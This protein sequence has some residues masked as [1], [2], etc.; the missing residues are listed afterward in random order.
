MSTTQRE[1]TKAVSLGTVDAFPPGSRR[2]VKVGRQTIAVFNIDG[3][4]HAIYGLCPH[5]FAPLS[6]GKLQGTLI[7]GEDTDWEKEWAYDG[8]VVVCPGHAMEFHVKTG[9]AFG[10]DFS[11]RTYDVVIDDGEILLLL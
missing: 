5:Q 8:E 9:K 11:L 3:E 7:C 1:R 6:R 10:Y 2:E 4:Y